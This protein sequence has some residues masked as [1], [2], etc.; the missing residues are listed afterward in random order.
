MNE[1]ALSRPDI[2]P[3]RAGEGK[4]ASAR[5]ATTRQALAPREEGGRRL[6]D[7]LP[8]TGEQDRCIPRLDLGYD[9]AELL[10][11]LSETASTF[12]WFQFTLR[13]LCDVFPHVMSTFPVV[14]MSV[15]K[16][17]TISSML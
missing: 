16:F 8:R 7:P 11:L 17:M 12:R 15:T 14:V 5:V 3:A 1:R 6:A 2:V 10:K 13:P 4:S 9:S